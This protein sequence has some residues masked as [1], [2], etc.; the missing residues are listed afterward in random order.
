M[1]FTESGRALAILPCPQHVFFSHSYRSRHT[2]SLDKLVCFFA[3]FVPSLLLSTGGE[4]AIPY[5][6]PNLDLKPVLGYYADGREKKMIINTQTSLEATPEV[7]YNL[8]TGF[9]LLCSALHFLWGGGASS[10]VE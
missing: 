5:L 2:T 3:L 4:R 10:L 1:G 7:C 6:S 8:L 9:V